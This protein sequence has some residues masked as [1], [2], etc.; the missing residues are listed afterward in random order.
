M[1][2]LR[3]SLRSL[4]LLTLLA[5][6]GCRSGE[7]DA[8]ATTDDL[9]TAR[10]LAFAVRDLASSPTTAC[11]DA[12][13]RCSAVE[14]VCVLRQ[15]EAAAPPLCAR[16]NDAAPHD[17]ATLGARLCLNGFWQCF[18]APELN[19]IYCECPNC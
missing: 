3:C 13:L 18:D 9:G 16:A 12:D 4:S 8:R 14:E 2:R 5:L 11:G 7:L 6:T 19:T 15:G 17:C 10:D 1:M